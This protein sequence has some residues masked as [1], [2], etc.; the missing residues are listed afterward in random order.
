MRSVVE[1]KQVEIDVNTFIEKIK[2]FEPVWEALTWKVSR[3]PESGQK[4][5]SICSIM[6]S[7][8]SAKNFP[9][10][11]IAYT[12]DKQYVNIEGVKVWKLK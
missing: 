10:V 8:Q 2:N 9:T 5:E 4:I 6:V 3:K 12:Y 1:S 7:D 11:S